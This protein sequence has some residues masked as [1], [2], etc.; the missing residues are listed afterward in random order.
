MIDQEYEFYDLYYD[1]WQE[2]FGNSYF[3]TRQAVLIARLDE[4]TV[5]RKLVKAKEAGIVRGERAY[6]GYGA[7]M[8]WSFG[9]KPLEMPDI[10]EP[11]APEKISLE[12]Q[13]FGDERARYEE[14]KTYHE[15]FGRSYPTE[16]TY[17]GQKINR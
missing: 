14:I 11:V 16:R 1:L 5:R 10:Y 17:Y 2:A 7:Y 4:K 15:K 12:P 9:N 13:L 3:T 8:F 6:T